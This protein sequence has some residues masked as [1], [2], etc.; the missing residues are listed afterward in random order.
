MLSNG[1]RH[2]LGLV[3]GAVITPL[4]AAAL[5]FGT[6]QSSKFFAYLAYDRVEQIPAYASLVVAAVLLGL[7]SGSRISP[8]ASLVPGAAFTLTGVAWVVSP[9]SR[10]TAEPDMLPATLG[11]GYTTLGAYGIFL[12]L[13]SL[14]LMASLPPSRWRAGATAE[15][16]PAWRDGLPADHAFGGVPP[17]FPPPWPQPQAPPLPGAAPSSGDNGSW[18]QVIGGESVADQDGGAA[19]SGWSDPSPFPGLPPR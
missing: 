10:V 3:V 5:M 2:G 13:G 9:V 6:G 16:E 19:P 1:A 8:L 18:T 11:R 14:L 12:M 4:A 15:A 17:A 7:A